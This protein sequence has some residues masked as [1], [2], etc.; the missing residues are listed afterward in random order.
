MS[1]PLLDLI[2]DLSQIVLGLL[3]VLVLP[4]FAFTAAL[5]PRRAPTLRST[6]RVVFT[7]GLSLAITALSGFLLNWTSTGLRAESWYV[8]LSGVTLV[9]WI[10][11]LLR[12]KSLFEVVLSKPRIGRSF[13]QALLPVAVAAGLIIISLG[14][15]RAGALRQRITDFTQLWMLP[16]IEPQGTVVRLGI[17]NLELGDSTY[18]VRLSVGSRVIRQWTEIK[19]IPEQIWETSILLPTDIDGNAAEALLFRDG[20]M[21]SPYRKVMLWLKE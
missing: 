16:Q 2:G 13:V 1:T 8:V 7:F 5:F 19:L 20:N 10:G 15:A 3:L 21:Q 18:T 11:A 4:G 6:E 9:G 12:D 14:L 17:R